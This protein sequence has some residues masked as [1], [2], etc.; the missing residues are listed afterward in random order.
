MS[1]FELKRLDNIKRNEEFLK[2]IGIESVKP[3]PLEARVKYRSSPQK[4]GNSGLIKAF[5][6]S[7][8]SLRLLEKPAPT[9]DESVI[10]NFSA[11]ED[12]VRNAKKHKTQS[13]P[14]IE[15]LPPDPDTSRAINAQLEPMLSTENLG[16]KVSD[17]GK[18]YVMAQFNGGLLPRFSKYS[19]VAEFKNCVILWVN[20]GKEVS[21]YPNTFSKSGRNINWFGGNKMTSGKVIF[22]IMYKIV[23]L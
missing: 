3:T 15:R 17:F 13:R 9:F 20:I 18:A 19:G 14:P 8:I 16:F 10:E 21:D 1:E 7:R 6:P 23:V 22:N 4:R 12:T 2:N 5:Q 11:L